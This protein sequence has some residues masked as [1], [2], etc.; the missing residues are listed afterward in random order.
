MSYNE[1][2]DQLIDISWDRVTKNAESK[3]FIYFS[4]IIQLINQMEN[5]LECDSL[6][7][8]EQIQ[9]LNL[10]IDEKPLLKLFKVDLASF[11]MKLVQYPNLETFLRERT[12]LSGSDLRRKL[13]LSYRRPL[14]PFK[15][16]DWA[17]EKSKFTTSSIYAPSI[18]PASSR[19]LLSPP[20]SPPIY[21]KF[22]S[23]GLSDRQKEERDIEVAALSKE[24]IHLS[25][26]NRAQ[27]KRIQ[28]LEKETEAL[29]AYINSLE[30]QLSSSKP[31]AKFEIKD[32][33]GT[34]AHKDRTIN[35]LQERCQKLEEEVKEIDGN[36]SG[37]KAFVQNLAF[38]L[39][40]QDKLIKELKLRLSLDTPVEKR[41]IKTL[42]Q[43]L[44]FIKQYYY[45][46]K[47]RHEQNHLGLIV[48]NIITLLFTTIIL[49]NLI[50]T[51]FYFIFWVF[52]NRLATDYIFEDDLNSWI[53]TESTF[54]WWKEIEWLEYIIYRLSDY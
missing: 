42:L 1:L 28:D 48:I 37:N 12:N 19:S 35:N 31:S 51:T 54:V 34:I 20:L 3:N 41:K 38:A 18:R 13:E 43:N 40:S 11:I 23:S 2:I 9:L 17:P 49:L 50:K 30:K 24:S 4:Q 25:S 5:L 21:N 26:K 32:L 36:D 8:D 29:N 6:F 7:T 27:S 45:F 16:R 44:P 53:T 46:F 39:E 33:L 47:Y 22:G 14:S 10:I 15:Q 52:N